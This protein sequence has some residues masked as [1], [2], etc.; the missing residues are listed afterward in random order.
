MAVVRTFWYGERLS[1]YEQLCFTSFVAHGHTLMVYAYTKLEVPPGVTVVD[2]ATVIPESSVFVYS[3]GEGAG[4]PSAFS[5]LFRYELLYRYGGW[6]SDTDVI[7]LSPELPA[8]DVVF[9]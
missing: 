9:G 1:P 8:G 2:A 3:S 5:N 7:C 6:W 4:S